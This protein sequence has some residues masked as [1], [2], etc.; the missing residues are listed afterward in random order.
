[1]FCKQ[2]IAYTVHIDW[3]YHSIHKN[4]CKSQHIQEGKG[5]S[6][7]GERKKE[8]RGGSF[9][10]LS[11]AHPCQGLED[12]EPGAGT[13]GHFPDVG[14]EGEVGV[15]GDSQ[16]LRGPAEGKSVAVAKTQMDRA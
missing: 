14:E 11:P 10:G 8:Q 2:F 3:Y 15:K 4:S 6:R 12:A 1:M 9:L 5:E 13:F 16:K 7:E